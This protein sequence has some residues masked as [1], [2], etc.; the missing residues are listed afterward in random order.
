MEK[1][2][3]RVKLTMVT[4]ESVERFKVID[5]KNAADQL[6]KIL[7]EDSID[8]YESCVA[9]FFDQSNESVGWFLVSQGGINYSVVDV[10]MVMSAALGCLAT[11]M[12]ICHNHPS[13]SLKPS[14]ADIKI[15]KKLKDACGILDIKF[16]DH[17]ILTEQSH[18]SFADE[19]LI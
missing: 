17:I 14:D 8:V 13:G 2:T 15:T 3:K 11:G 5:S 4:D 12:I 16:L 10:R 18:Y 7:P 19:G 9:V 1:Y 6:R